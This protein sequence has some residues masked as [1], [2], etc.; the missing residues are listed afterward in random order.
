MDVEAT[1]KNRDYYIRKILC[2]IKRALGVRASNGHNPNW[3]PGN[4]TFN[5]PRLSLRQSPAIVN[6]ILRCFVY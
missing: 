5:H 2:I 3:F 4:L 1:P 6:R